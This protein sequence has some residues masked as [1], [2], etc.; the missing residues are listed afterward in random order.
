MTIPYR[1]E[2]RPIWTLR[3]EGV[4]QKA[5]AIAEKEAEKDETIGGVG[6]D[7]LAKALLAETE[8]PHVAILTGFRAATAGAE[9]VKRFGKTLKK[10]ADG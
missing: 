8:G 3:A 2:R 7:H 1:T 10:L 6:T 9:A 5:I 4:L